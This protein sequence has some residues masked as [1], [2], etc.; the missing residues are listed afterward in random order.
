VFVSGNHTKQVE[1]VS[2]A[3]HRRGQPWA[4]ATVRSDP[5][6]QRQHGTGFFSIIVDHADPPGG[7]AR[8][9]LYATFDEAPGWGSTY[10]VGSWT[11][12]HCR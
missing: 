5:K 7:Q 1:S 9:R 11:A 4:M 3:A 6:H 12:T 10:L 8:G 2:H